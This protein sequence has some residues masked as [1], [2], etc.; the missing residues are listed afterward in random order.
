[1][2]RQDRSG[3][4]TT[5]WYSPHFHTPQSSLAVFLELPSRSPKFLRY[6]L[7][8][9]P[10]VSLHWN[11]LSVTV[12]IDPRYE[13][14]LI[15]SLQRRI[16]H[17][18]ETILGIFVHCYYE[19]VR[20]VDMSSFLASGTQSESTLNSLLH[21]VHFSNL[22]EATMC[23][24][25]TCLFN[26]IH[27]MHFDEYP[28]IV[29][30]VPS[31]TYAHRFAHHRRHQVIAPS[32]IMSPCTTAVSGRMMFPLMTILLTW[33]LLECLLCPSHRNHQQADRCFTST[34]SDLP[35]SCILMTI[36][37]T[38]EDQF[39]NLSDRNRNSSLLYIVTTRQWV[40]SPICCAQFQQKI[41]FVMDPHHLVRL[42][43]PLPVRFIL[44]LLL[45]VE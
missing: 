10:I 19:F 23:R 40:G 39:K 27:S 45:S 44:F 42:Y 22:N 36:Y 6:A 28:Q 18:N 16:S 38:S 43:E 30:F 35:E 12:S 15:H 37:N 14:D 9:W 20:L 17:Q 33:R 31:R 11:L 24:L 2:H 7:P 29:R 5:R 41:L 3:Y 1:M 21:V 34:W 13:N 25:M 26:T 8:N 4:I 32:I